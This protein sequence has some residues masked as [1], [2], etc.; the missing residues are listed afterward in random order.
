[1]TLPTTAVAAPR[2]AAAPRGLGATLEFLRYFA[3][4]AAALAV[5]MVLYAGALRLGLP[6]AAAALLGFTA[7]A[8]AAYVASVRWVFESRNVRNSTMEFGLFVA[9]GVGGLLIT[10]GLLWLFIEQLS[11]PAVLSKLGTSGFVFVF[12]FGVRKALLF[13]AGAR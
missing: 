11:W 6:Y 4:S 1:M 9:V 7:G 8:A 10:E 5:D 12:N 3:A 2:L 13:R